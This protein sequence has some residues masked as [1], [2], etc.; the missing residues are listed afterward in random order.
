MHSSICSKAVK[1]QWRSPGPPKYLLCPDEIENIL[2]TLIEQSNILI[3][4][5]VGQVVYCQLIESSYT[6]VKCYTSGS[7]S[8]LSVLVHFFCFLCQSFIARELHNTQSKCHL[9]RL[10]GENN[11]VRQARIKYLLMLHCILKNMI[12]QIPS[13]LLC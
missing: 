1:C 13:R 3:K 8:N 12:K 11:T 4:Q 7:L 6:T 5:S 2:N 9:K 10:N